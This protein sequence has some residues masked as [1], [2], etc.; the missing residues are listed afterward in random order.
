MYVV[1]G[2]NNRKDPPRLLDSIRG[3]YTRNRHIHFY[4]YSRESPS[5]PPKRS[6][7]RRRCEIL[8]SKSG[9][10]RHQHLHQSRCACVEDVR[11][12]M[13]KTIKKEMRRTATSARRARRDSKFPGHSQVE[14]PESSRVMPRHA[15][16]T[17]TAPLFHQNYL[18]TCAP[19]HATHELSPQR[20]REN[21][22]VGYRERGWVAHAAI[23]FA[24]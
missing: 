24:R 18:Q 10:D 12:Q 3:L 21:G 4:T 8:D 20:R 19:A 2:H 15:V 14:H 22:V 11:S 5:T 23:P 17:S 16:P 1:D 6:Q 13:T 9:A 7:S